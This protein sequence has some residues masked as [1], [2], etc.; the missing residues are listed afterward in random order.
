MKSYRSEIERLTPQ[1]RQVARALVEDGRADIADELVHDAVAEALRWDQGGLAEQAQHRMYA[2]LIAANR[3]RLRNAVGERRS[4]PAPFSNAES[5]PAPQALGFGGA[6]EGGAG[7]GALPLSDR[8]VLVLVVLARLDYHEVTEVLGIPMATLVTRLTRARDA[9][10]TSLWAAGRA[11]V[12]HAA[13]PRANPGHLR[14]VK[15]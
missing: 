10:G 12:G 6:G 15:S 7:L 2:R 13:R 3:M 8:E 5:K 1:L 4:A 11:P 9:L 14:L